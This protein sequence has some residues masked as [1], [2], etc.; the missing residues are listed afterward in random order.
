MKIILDINK[1]AANPISGEFLEKVVRETIKVSGLG[2]LN[3]KEINVSLAFLDAR[4]IKKINKIYRRKNS[5]TD[6]L[7]FANYRDKKA[8]SREKNKTIYLGE[9]LADYE[10]IKKSAKLNEVGAN[11]ELVCV[12]S[13]GIL[14]LLGMKHSQKMF[15]LQDKI[16]KVKKNG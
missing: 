5:S 13:H 7:S 4:E 9:L 12:I 3:K 11:V 14:H 6:I 15:A 1:R 10:Y 8:L 2:F 16:I